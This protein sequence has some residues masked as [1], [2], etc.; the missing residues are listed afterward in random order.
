MRGALALA[1]L[2]WAG[3]RAMPALHPGNWHEAIRPG[4]ASWLVFFAVNGCKHCEQMAPTMEML[5]KQ[6]QQRGSEVRVGRVSV[7]EHNGIGRTFGL[8]RFPTVLLFD[9]RDE[10]YYEF[11]GRRGL[12]VLLEFAEGGYRKQGGAPTPDH[13]LG[14]VSEAWLMALTLWDPMK[15]SLMY[16]GGVHRVIRRG[17]DSSRRA[18]FQQVLAGHRARTQAT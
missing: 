6:L 14:D 18:L 1:F 11:E 3:A 17:C 15:T 10:L 4:G 2:P 5:G 8:K 16:V 9:G 13:L 12:P 7:S